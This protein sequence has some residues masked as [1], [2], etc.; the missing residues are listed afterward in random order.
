MNQP[1]QLSQP[2]APTGPTGPTEPDQRVANDDETRGVKLSVAGSL[3][4][5][6]SAIVMAIVGR[7]QAILLDG[8]YTFITLMLAFASLRVIKLLK[9]PE[10]KNRPFGYMAFEPFLNIFKS[11]VM[12]TVLAVF[13]VT[14]IQEL[15]TGGR[16]V[17]LDAMVLYIALCLVVYAAV[18]WR[19]RRYGKRVQSSILALEIKNWTIDAMLTVGIMVSLMIAL[20][21]IELGHVGI[22]PYI[23]P[24]IVIGLVVLSLPVPIKVLVTEFKQLTLISD[25]NR[26]E[27]EVLEQIAPVIDAHAL[28]A[29]Q[30]WGLK[31]GRSVYLFVYAGLRD[32]ATTLT[33]LDAIRTEIFVELKKRYPVFW[34]D[35]I[36]TRID[37]QQP[38]PY[39][40]DRELKSE[41]DAGTGTGT[42]H[43]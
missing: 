31:A 27:A 16:L 3:V 33:Q 6:T 2:T 25:E 26:L 9:E 14:S 8:L 11:L 42:D 12:L 37:P 5:S 17:E 28:Q 10:T 1:S 13:L 19:L 38:F 4:L 41:P 24:V 43:R 40:A 39:P 22:L 23:D 20:L 21:V 29:V 18:L 30:V 36:F 35:I 34:A 7:S 15:M 32:D